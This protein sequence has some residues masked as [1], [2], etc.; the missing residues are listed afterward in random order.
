LLENYFQGLWKLKSKLRHGVELPAKYLKLWRQSVGLLKDGKTHGIIVPPAEAILLMHV[1][2]L[3]ASFM[4][5]AFGKQPKATHR[6]R[7]TAVV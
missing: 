2:W 5:K 1:V 4:A 3:D 7:N 6:D